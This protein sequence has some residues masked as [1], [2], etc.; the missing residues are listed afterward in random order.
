MATEQTIT[1]NT[2]AI[3]GNAGLLSLAAR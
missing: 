3:G 1:T 2:S